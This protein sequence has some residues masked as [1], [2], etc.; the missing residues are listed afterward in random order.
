MSID[1]QITY[2]QLSLF[3]TQI[4]FFCFEPLD[5]YG[6]DNSNFKF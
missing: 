6:N 5:G 1:W 2:T 3:K 4:F